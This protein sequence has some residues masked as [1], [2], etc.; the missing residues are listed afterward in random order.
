MKQNTLIAFGSVPK[1][2]G[3]FTFY[4]NLRK[5]LLAHGIDLRCVSVGKREAQLWE[6]SYADEGCVLLAEN[7]SSIKKQSQVFTQWCADE[8]VD[9][10]FGVNSIA[11]LS[12]LPHLPS[13]IRVM[14]RCANAFDHGYR[15][16]MSCHERLNRVVA[17]APRQITDLVSSYGADERRIVLIPNGTSVERFASAANKKRGTQQSLRL[18]FLGRLEHNQKGVLYLPDVLNRL[19]ERGVEFSLSIAGKGVHE[20]TLRQQFK[21]HIEAGTVKFVGALKREE[22]AGYF[23]N[24]DVYLFPSQF[25]GSPNALIE[26]LMAGCVPAAWKL[27]GITDFVVEDGA[28]GV[29]ADLGDCEGL[30]DAISML[31]N[32]RERLKALS[33]QAYESARKRF[34]RERLI[35]DYVKLIN[36]VMA[37]PPLPWQVKDWQ[38]FNVDPAFRQPAW[39]KMIPPPLKTLAKQIMYS[40]RMDSLGE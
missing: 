37:E 32:D 35:S 10:V 28:T 16:T 11:I 39:K 30:A 14:A 33:A 38:Q 26:A 8:G 24:I 40:L 18:G 20:S 3:T 4:K 12:A 21:N 31:A 29:L 23:S 1:D 6:H 34:S 19:Q 22:I 25:E 2:G 36:E 5:P 9:I 17:L 15:I 13:H 27:K 7:V